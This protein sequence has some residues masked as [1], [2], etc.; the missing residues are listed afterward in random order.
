M[1]SLWNCIRVDLRSV[2]AGL[3][4]VDAGPVEGPTLS[5][6]AEKEAAAAV[7]E[8]AGVGSE[9]MRSMSVV[10][11]ESWPDAMALGFRLTPPTTSGD[12]ERPKGGLC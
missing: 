6:L 5:D 2:L 4:R 11:A 1:V 12:K 7:E 9:E 8:A 10:P 3:R